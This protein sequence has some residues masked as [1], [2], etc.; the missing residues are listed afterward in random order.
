MGDDYN[1][2]R[3]WIGTDARNMNERASDVPMM[4]LRCATMNPSKTR[5]EPVKDSIAAR[6]WSYRSHNHQ[7]NPHTIMLLYLQKVE[8]VMQIGR[9]QIQK[10]GPALCDTYQTLFLHALALVHG[11]HVLQFVTMD[12]HHY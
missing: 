11:S 4:C 9:N 8:W 10:V 12:A 1:H 3:V 5:Y 6:F 2:R 7:C